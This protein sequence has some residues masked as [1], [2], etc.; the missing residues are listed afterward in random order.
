MW[1][2]LLAFGRVVVPA[3]QAVAVVLDVRADDLAFP[4]DDM[5]LR[6]H[7]GAYVASVGFSS[8]SD[9]LVAPFEISESTLLQRVVVRP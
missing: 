5:R 3:A 2:R 7:R 8:A 1:K 4:G 9:R 6:L